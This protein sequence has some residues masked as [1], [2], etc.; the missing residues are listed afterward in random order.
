MLP[1]V[2]ITFHVSRRAIDFWPLQH[3]FSHQPVQCSTY[4]GKMPDKDDL[5]SAL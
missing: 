1:K 4:I 2:I 5:L 3:I